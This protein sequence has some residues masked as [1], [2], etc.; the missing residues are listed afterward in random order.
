MSLETLGPRSL[1]GGPVRGARLVRLTYFDDAGLFNKKQEPFIVIGGCIVNADCQLDA[2]ERAIRSI[3]ECFIPKQDLPGFVFH[4]TELWS[5]GKYFQRDR[6]PREKRMEILHALAEIPQ[7]LEIPLSF[8]FQER[9]AAEKFARLH[10]VRLDWSSRD[11][12]LSLYADT[13]ARFAES[14]ELSMREA[15]PDEITILIGEDNPN[16][17]SLTKVAHNHFRDPEWV[18]NINGELTYFPFERIKEGVHFSPKQESVPL[19]LADLATFCIKKRL[20]KDRDARGL[21]AKLKPMM[22]FHPK[23]V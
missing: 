10:G 20:V 21:Y 3:A 22:L 16:I 15:W 9:A 7:R 11:L 17:R 18:K 8:G 2:L 19:Q 23:G 1:C 6:W 12:E 5:G 4:A 13:Y 14:I